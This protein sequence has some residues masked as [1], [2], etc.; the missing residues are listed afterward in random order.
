MTSSTAP[1]EAPNSIERR[2]TER[3]TLEAEVTLTATQTFSG[4]S[5]DVSP[6]GVF[7][8]T[9][10]PL[11]VGQ[12]VHVEFDLLGGHV[13]ADGVVT[14]MRTASE[15]A[16]PGVGIAFDAIGARDRTLLERFCAARAPLRAT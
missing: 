5:G 13:V 8:D 7:V 11:D 1:T 14:W 16:A 15:Q 6:C 9:Y 10:Q 2:R 3:I 12:L 4:L